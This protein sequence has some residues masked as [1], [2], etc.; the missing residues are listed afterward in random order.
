MSPEVLLS[1]DYGMPSDVFS[2]GIIFVEMV[3]GKE[4]TPE[5]PQ[6][7]PQVSLCLLVSLRVSLCV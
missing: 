2:L 1:E 5:F 3:T 6:R 4:P 7:L